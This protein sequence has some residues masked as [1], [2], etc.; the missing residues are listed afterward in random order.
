MT[1]SW[2][3]PARTSVGNLGGRPRGWALRPAGR[4]LCGWSSASPSCSTD[5]AL[6]GHADRREG[7][8]PGSL[9]AKDQ[10]SWLGPVP[11]PSKHR[12][13]GSEEGALEPG[14]SRYP[15]GVGLSLSP[16]W[17]ESPRFE[18]RPQGPS[19]SEV[20]FPGGSEGAPRGGSESGCVAEACAH[21]PCGW[22]PLFGAVL[23]P[24]FFSPREGVREFPVVAA[25]SAPLQF[26]CPL[27]WRASCSRIFL[28]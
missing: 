18:T 23:C 9:W 3:E 21:A 19:H 15:P 10:G 16:P 8:G 20:A 25:R 24:V 26:S 13:P 28:M 4:A 14:A 22:L 27:R 2:S 7:L 17:A 6:G 12:D 1:S 11:E 5:C